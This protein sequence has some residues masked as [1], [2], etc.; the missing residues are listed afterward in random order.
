MLVDVYR[1]TKPLNN[2]LTDLIVTEIIL[3]KKK[4]LVNFVV[5]Q[6]YEKQEKIYEIK[7]HDFSEGVYNVHEFYVKLSHR[8]E[9]SEEHLT[10]ELYWSCKKD[11]KE[12]WKE[13]RERYRKKH[14]KQSFI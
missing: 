13:Y 10:K 5:L 14:L 7:K 3:D 9:F 1:K 2:N 12:N 8:Q 6:L 11:I 4:K